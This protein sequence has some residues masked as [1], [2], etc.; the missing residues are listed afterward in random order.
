MRAIDRAHRPLG[1]FL[2]PL[3]IAALYAALGLLALWVGQTTGLASPV[4][5]AA[6]VA[7]TAA[8]VW[9]WRALPGVIL[10]SFAVNSFW[11][12]HVGENGAVLWVTALGIGIGATLQ[13][14]LGAGLVR[15]FVGPTLH[16]DMPKR[17]LLTLLL[18]GPIACL[19][20]PT[21]GVATQL[22]TGIISPGNATM[23]WL[24]WWVGDAI[25]V[26]V[27]APLML[28]LIPS[29]RQFW[30]GRR[31]AVAAPSLLIVAVLVTVILQNQAFERERL[32]IAVGQLGD[33]ATADLVSNL[34]RNEE[35]LRG[36]RGLLDAS[37]EV[38]ADEFETYTRDILGRSSDLAA[39]SWNPLIARDDLT[40]FESAMR[41]QPGFTDYTVTERDADGNL[42]PVGVR[43]EYVAVA[44]IEPLADNLSALGY[45]I[46]SNPARALAIDEARDSGRT[47]GTAPIELVQESG[48][49]AGM[50]VLMPVYDGG[51]DPGTS[52][53][54][55]SALRGFAVGVYRL[56][57]LLE[58]TFAGEKW[59]DISITLLDVT[60]A[61]DPVV[62]ADLPSRNPAETD[63]VSE[64]PTATTIPIDAY[65]RSW[66]LS[67]QPTGQALDARSTGLTI[68][69]LLSALAVAFLLEVLLLLLSGMEAR[70]RRQALESSYEANHDPLTGLS[71]RRAFVRD[72]D[73][74]L[75]A[76]DADY[77][78][79]LLFCDLDRFKR[80]NDTG[81]HAAGDEMLLAAAT[82]MKAQVRHDDLVA[83]MG[84]DEFAILLKDCTL[85]D[86]LPIAE[87][88]VE[89]VDAARLPPPLETLS[90]GISVGV[91]I[92]HPSSNETL[93]EHLRH[94]DKASYEAKMAGGSR[95]VVYDDLPSQ[96]PV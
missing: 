41:Q 22:T 47:T 34:E 84:G 33:Q 62:I 81:G 14:A 64:T 96:T 59:D 53:S 26:I 35:S 28:M 10:G 73:E 42:I 55:R 1:V 66:E 38:T 48:S 93:D 19:V 36:L 15:R 52:I 8:A 2:I 50:L 45:D 39:M 57:T 68:T 82:E 65:G 75:E 58:E 31:L 16:L 23:G 77:T 79:I 24:T 72:F 88:I 11:L 83:R 21:V 40:A 70:A 80:V 6:G 18:A 63:E 37:D 29:Q 32:E 78:D 13:A 3:V 51:E 20:G 85:R 7:F 17:I 43:P 87:A 76:R 71:N 67:V 30:A 49:Q 27:F 4:W 60:D 90:V 25:G 89:S 54:R 12:W 95:V 86:A 44:Y 94:A 56:G 69:L 92:V 46:Y 74:I 9:R 91:A 61:G 5:P